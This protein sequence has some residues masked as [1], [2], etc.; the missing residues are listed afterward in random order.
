MAIKKLSHKK[1]TKY[2]DSLDIPDF[3]LLDQ[4]PKQVHRYAADIVSGKILSCKWI[5]LAAER[6]FNDMYRSEHDDSFPFVF[7]EFKAK[8]IID[9]YKFI[10]HTKGVLARTPIQLL[11][12]QQFLLGSIIGWVKKENGLRRFKQANIW[13]ARKNG[14]STIASGLAL[15]L[16]VADNETGAEIYSVATKIDQARI[17]WD[18]AVRMLG[19]SKLKDMLKI[20]KG[21]NEILCDETFSKFTPLS[22]DSNSLDGLNIHCFIADEIHAWKDRNLYGVLETA[23]GSRTQP[24]A[25]TI[26][27]AG[28]ILDGVGKDIF[29]DGLSILQDYGCEEE[30]F[31]MNYTIDSKDKWN[32]PTVWGKSNPCLGHSVQEDDILRLCRKAERLNSE[33]PNFLTK[34]LNI[35]VN[36]AEA[37]FDQNKI[38]ACADPTAKIENFKGQECYIG[39]DFAEYVDLASVCYLFPNKNGTFNV[40]YDNFLPH[41]ALDKVSEQMR[42]RYYALDD[43]GWLNILSGDVMDHATL[44]G[45]LREAKENY[46]LK[47][48]AYDPYHLTQIANQ[49]EKERYPMVSVTQTIANLSEAAKLMS[50][51]IE[52]KQL[53]YNGDKTFEWCCSNTMAKVDDKANVKLFRENP[54]VH[55]IDAV[56]ATVIAISMAEIQEK[57]VQT[58]YKDRGFRM[59]F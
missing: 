57:P 9:F 35:F 16:L 36:N 44:E 37:Y 14:K 41:S 31:T 38:Y 52:S 30:V 20:R 32:D 15:F 54:R 27:T 13:V 29:D 46:D 3:N 47:S 42:Q 48:I 53:I 59:L 25:F 45:V 51:Y 4:H 8:N 50:K 58:I 6:H 2:I 18:D 12:W 33:R 24:I 5:K 7:S 43:E 26:S 21:R 1:L 56:I 28:W 55:K 11:P 22:S 10:K 34:R 17:V 39:I 40:F 23:T 19:M 49:L